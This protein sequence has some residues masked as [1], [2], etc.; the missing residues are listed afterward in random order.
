MLAK[1]LSL[2]DPYIIQN[3]K[4][5]FKHL[6]FACCCL[7]IYCVSIP[8]AVVVDALLG[9]LDWPKYKYAYKTIHVELYQGIFTKL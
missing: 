2:Y 8:S 7:V 1:L 9:D 5:I 3:L 6:L 4:W